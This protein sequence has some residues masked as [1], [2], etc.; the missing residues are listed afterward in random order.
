MHKQL[1]MIHKA[2][3]AAT[4]TATVTQTALSTITAAGF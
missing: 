4:I 2:V 1:I 3:I